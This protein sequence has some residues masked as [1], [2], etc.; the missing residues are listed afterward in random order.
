MPQ[1]AVRGRP[2]PLPS[3]HARRT[4][5]EVPPVHPPGEGSPELARALGKIFTRR[6]VRV[7]LLAEHGVLAAGDDL[8]QAQNLA[9]SVEESARIVLLASLLDRPF[10]G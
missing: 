6:E 8:R 7:V 1:S 2:L 5:V 9:E 10:M 3:V 4:L